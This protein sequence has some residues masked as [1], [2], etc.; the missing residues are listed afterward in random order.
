V[1]RSGG[2][3][4]RL[5]PTATVIGLFPRWECETQTFVLQPGDL[6]LIYTDGVTEANNAWGEEFGEARLRQTVQENL[7]LSTDEILAAIQVQVQKFSAGE[8]TDDLTL[9]VARAR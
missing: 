7:S 5:S 6:L 9:V 3:V 1:F 4:E 2:S 8:Q